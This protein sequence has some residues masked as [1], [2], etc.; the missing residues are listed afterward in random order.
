MFTIYN[1]RP[2]P[3]VKKKGPEDDRDISLAFP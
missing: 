1:T 2:L 3:G